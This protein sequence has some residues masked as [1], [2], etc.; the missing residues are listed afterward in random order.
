VALG[1]KFH[2]WYNGLLHPTPKAAAQKLYDDVEAE[3]AS[4]QP[5]ESELI[6]PAS[7]RRSPLT[8]PT[9]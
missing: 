9:N 3:L 6:E 7:S 2:A 4:A 1:P 8:S 5:A